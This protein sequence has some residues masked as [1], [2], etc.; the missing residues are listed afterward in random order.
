MSYVSS[1]NMIPGKRQMNKN[2]QII[3]LKENEKERKYSVKIIT[4]ETNLHVS[5]KPPSSSSRKIK[6]DDALLF[7]TRRSRRYKP[8]DI[9]RDL[10]VLMPNIDARKRMG[11]GTLESEDFLRC[12]DDVVEYEEDSDGDVQ[13]IAYISLPTSVLNDKSKETISAGSNTNKV[14]HI[15]RVTLS[16]DD[17]RRPLSTPRGTETT[18]SSSPGYRIASINDVSELSVHGSERSAFPSFSDD[19][20]YDC[21]T[22]DEVFIQLCNSVGICRATSLSLTQSHVMTETVLEQLV[23]S[24]EQQL[25]WAYDNIEASGSAHSTVNTCEE[26]LSDV[27]GWVQSLNQCFDPESVPDISLLNEMLSENLTYSG[28]QAP[29]LTMAHFT[30][31]FVGDMPME[32]PYLPSS[33]AG[34]RS[35]SRKMSRGRQ[36]VLPTPKQSDAVQTHSEATSYESTPRNPNEDIFSS[37]RALASNSI[38]NARD[39][40]QALLPLSKA[41]PVLLEL[42]R[43]YSPLKSIQCEVSP[44]PTLNSTAVESYLDTLRPHNLVCVELEASIQSPIDLSVDHYLATLVYWY[45]VSKRSLQRTSLIRSYQRFSMRN[46]SRS[47]PR[48]PY[49]PLCRVKHLAG[50]NAVRS[51]GE[52]EPSRPQTLDSLEEEANG[53]EQ[54]RWDLEHVRTIVDRVRRREKVKRDYF[55]VT[56]TCLSGDD[57]SSDCYAKHSTKL[58]HE[59]PLRAITSKKIFYDSE[60]RRVGRP[61]KTSSNMDTS[62]VDVA[63]VSRRKSFDFGGSSILAQRESE[64]KRKRRESISIVK[65]SEPGAV[66]K[67]DMILWL[68]D[69]I[70]LT[71]VALYGIGRWME[72]KSRFG[73]ALS[74]L[75]AGLIALRFS[76]LCRRRKENQPLDSSDLLNTAWA[77]S[78]FFNTLNQEERLIVHTFDEE[79]VGIIRLS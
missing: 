66:S 75:R 73:S 14:V 4:E 70:L 24:L 16:S 51:V 28:S 53:L 72:I 18:L 37:G 54:L 69:K 42:F 33:W 78:D 67:K 12:M 11:V 15:P 21:D 39:K 19:Q 1:S 68:T 45:W 36:A 27:T 47:M 43:F 31:L 58:S 46:W 60:P 34:A 2:E 57:L 65:S 50:V 25:E 61:R 32:N 55:R 79:K 10:I 26:K 63:T 76:V 48:Y 22:E 8:V 64:K 62:D 20:D 56:G 38:K 23:A 17:L 7:S 74:N 49:V 44:T 29:E 9:F 40:L 52:S 59:S 13:P 30:D 3:M 5:R 71:G 77:E 6:N 35:L 41:H